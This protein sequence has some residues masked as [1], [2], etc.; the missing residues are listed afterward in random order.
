MRLSAHSTPPVSGR[1]HSSGRLWLTCM[2]FP[3]SCCADAYSFWFAGG[4]SSR[5]WHVPAVA[6]ACRRWLVARFP[7]RRLACLC[8]HVHAPPHRRPSG[9]H[10][11]SHLRIGALA[12]EGFFPARPSNPSPPAPLP[13]PLVLS[14]QS[15]VVGAILEF[16]RKN[17]FATT[18][19]LVRRL[20]LDIRPL[21]LPPPLS[22]FGH[23]FVAAV[24]CNLVP[25]QPVTY[26]QTFGWFFIGF[27]FE[28]RAQVWIGCR[29]G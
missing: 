4:V 3:C 21:P 24:K 26:S 29:S 14:Q 5:L 2:W 8:M 25:F 23:H 6:T 20:R 16:Q 7:S 12:E 27:A 1:P 22:L 17:V 28:V 11:C 15:M 9:M 18:M 10:T 19:G 13:P